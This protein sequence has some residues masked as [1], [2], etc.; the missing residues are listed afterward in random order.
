MNL[1]TNLDPNFAAFVDQHK[2]EVFRELLRSNFAGFIGKC[3]QTLNP[4][5]S[6]LHNWHIE[7][8]AF[9]LEQVRLGK[10]KRLIITM[11]PRSA[12]SIAASIAFPAFIHGH[13]PTAEIV[14]VS[15][16]QNLASKLHNDYRLVL[17]SDWYMALFGET[18]VDP[19]KETEQEVRLTKRGNRFATSVGGVLTGRGADIIIIDDPLK[20]DDAMSEA[21]RS[22]VNDWYSNTLPSRL[23]QKNEGAIVIVTQRLHID[24]LVG[25]VTRYD[26]NW[27]I[28]DLPAIA[29]EDQRIQVG[30]GKWYHRK[31]GEL[32][33]PERE[34]QSVFDELKAM[35]GASSFEA[36]YQQRPVPP[37]GNLFKSKWINYYDTLPEISDGVIL[38]SWDTAS[39]AG[40][41]NDW[42]VGTTWLYQDHF[43]YLI[44]VSREKLN[45]PD[46][47]ARV[48]AK[49]VE[50]DPWIVLIE[51]AGVGTGLIEELR[52]EGHNTIGITPSQS[53]EA[54]ATIET[55]KFQSSRVLLPRSAP[56]LDPLLSELLAF[57]GGR[58]DDQ[59]D[60]IV[61]ALAYE[62]V[63]ENGGV[64]YLFPRRC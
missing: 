9:H 35:L 27:T 64:E 20:P 41:A 4:G 52:R 54:R 50:F 3:F 44:D 36:Q 32:L 48:V 24:D 59:V 51:D 29:Y 28:L 5:T 57:P 56:W 14:A 46:L 18:R 26:E 21:Q 37:G 61:Q 62:D 31:R 23:N 13:D 11:P 8:I 38:Q 2:L 42:S 63:P 49:A 34:S 7:A 12:K 45:Y 30:T 16:A 22:R 33:H 25:H 15:Y 6:Y 39:K 58:H 53:K 55:A 10:I 19:K 40:L 43:Y 60:S 47:K 1:R 17:S